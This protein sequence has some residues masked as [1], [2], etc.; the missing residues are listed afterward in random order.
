MFCDTQITYINKSINRDVPKI[1]IFAS[2]AIP[3]FDTL[4]EGVAW[5]VIPD[6]GRASSS[7]FVF[8]IE[9]SVS[10]TWQDGQNKTKE[11]SSTIG[12]RY[13]V[14]KN[15]TGI[16]LETNGNASDT[17]SVEVT[18]DINVPNGVSAQ[19]YK[20]GKLMMEKKIVGFGQKT[21]FVLKPTLYWGVASEVQEGQP[22]NSAVLTSDQFF[23]QNLE[24][25]SKATVSLNGN[26]EEGYSFKIE[27]EE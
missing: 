12:K 6:I 17:N 23:P 8:P 11:L 10:A 20:E 13:T 1:F 22:L 24:G 15:D 19:L 3:S 7:S 4:K 2:N 25:V 18:N 9:T 26:A 27:N 16:V 14:A 5:R 21:T